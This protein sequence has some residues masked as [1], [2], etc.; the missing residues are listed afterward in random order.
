[1]K[2]LA[3]Q[4]KKAENLEIGTTIPAAE[5]KIEERNGL[6]FHLFPSFVATFQLR[7]IISAPCDSCNVAF[8]VYTNTTTKQSAWSARAT[9]TAA[10]PCNHLGHR[11]EW[12]W[13]QMA[14]Q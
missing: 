5:E 6:F 3:A 8:T 14:M 9:A 2:G 1:M 11:P 4:W 7:R 12:Q 10:E 13:N